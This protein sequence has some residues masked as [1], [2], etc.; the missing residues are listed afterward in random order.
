[1]RKSLVNV[2]IFNSKLEGNIRCPP[3]KSYTHRAIAIASLTTE[4]SII[5]N[6]LISRDTLA[7][8]LACKML[9]ATIEESFQS[10]LVIGKES[11]EVPNDIINAENSGTTIRIISS[12]SALVRKGYTILTGDESLRKR[13][14]MP[15]ISALNQLGVECFSTNEKGTPPLVIKGG[16]ISGGKVNI[17]GNISSQFISSL[18]ISGIFARSQVILNVNGKQVST[19]YIEATIETMK[20]F[21]VKIE[22]NVDYSEYIIPQTNYKGTLFN[23][24]ADFSAVALMISAGLLCGKKITIENLNFEYPQ[25]DKQIIDLVKKMGADIRVNNEKGEITVLGSN[26]LKG[27]ECDLSN[28]PDLLPAISILALK[29]TSPIKIYGISHARL[30]ETD[31]VSVI[32]SELRKLGVSVS[33]NR[34]EMVIYPIR[35]IKNAMLDSHNDHRLFMAFT[36]AALLTEK[37]IVKGAESVDVSYPVFLRDL[38]ILGAKIDLP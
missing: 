19:P 18:L 11:F 38:K 32:A 36:I 2:K 15:I 31:R 23:V 26:E 17:D 14:M 27:I 25:G 21:G 35:Q 10:L 8:I 34:D 24:P 6:P 30:K 13:P 28:T 4:N 1:M 20:N 16:G 5:K 33:D 9:G 37:S 7:T 29:S 22:H 3:S 12:M